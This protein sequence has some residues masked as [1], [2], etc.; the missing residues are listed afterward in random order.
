M[1]S[2][3][4]Q[5]FLAD[6]I[7]NKVAFFY[8]SQQHNTSADVLRSLLAQMSYGSDGDLVQPVR[9]WFELQ[10]G[11]PFRTSKELQ[12]SIPPHL[13]RK[14][15]SKEC[16]ELLSE[17][18]PFTMQTTLIID[19][20]DEC[21]DHDELLDHLMQMQQQ[22]SKLKIFISGRMGI[23]RKHE[24]IYN[25]IIEQFDSKSDLSHFIDCEIHLAARRDRSG[26]TPSQANTLRTLL[27][28]RADGM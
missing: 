25:Y 4:I 19:A 20:L 6:A 26:M 5:K 18:L 23:Y 10:T 28:S 8:C 15:S 3:I 22:F 7:D 17:I 11:L 13:A 9:D 21:Q 12:A 27:M 1:T 2:I 16:V 14:I 24:F